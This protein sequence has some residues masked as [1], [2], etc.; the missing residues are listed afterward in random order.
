MDWGDIW[1]QILSM[2]GFIGVLVAFAIG[3]LWALRARRKDAP[4]KVGE[5]LHH[6]QEIGIRASATDKRIWEGSVGLQWTV[7][8]KEGG[9]GSWLS[10]GGKE[11]WDWIW[12]TKKRLEGVIEIRGRQIDYIKVSSHVG[13][14]GV[15]Y[16]LDHLVRSPGHLGE[17][18]RKNT[19][20]VRK[21]KP[22]IWWG[23]IVDIEWQG[24]YH[25]SQLLNYDQ[26]LRDIV[27]ETDLKKLEGDIEIL[28]DSEREYAMVRTAYLL[29]SP[30]LLK[31]IDIIARHVKSWR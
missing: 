15:K 24:D 18:R 1:E 4:G 7:P 13:Q 10:R 11:L 2:S 12:G 22:A 21:K 19:K 17:N 16:F 6:L 5:L 29:P 30:D 23:K 14:H 27:L 8:E 9:A 3:V 20:M 26:R 31:A 25:L 28:P